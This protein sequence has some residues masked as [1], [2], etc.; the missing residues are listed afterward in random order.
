MKRLKLMTGVLAAGILLCG[1]VDDNIDKELEKLTEDNAKATTA[2]I[3]TKEQET[4]KETETTKEQETSKETETTEYEELT[5]TQQAVSEGILRELIDKNVYCNLYIFCG[6]LPLEDEEIETG[7]DAQTN[8]LYQV[9]EKAFPDYA[10]FEEY[11]RSVYCKE[12]ADMFLY[13]Y[14]FE[15]VQK[16]RDIDGKLYIDLKYDGGKGYYVIWDDY[17]ITIDSSSEDRCEFTV[18]A[19][20]EWPAENPVVEDYVVKGT[21]VYEN[22]RWVL[23]E[24]IY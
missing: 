15:G 2:V 22:N 6:S 8:S 3:T 20:V 18:K 23:T 14:P 17:T 7:T 16:Y 12:T 11:V 13:N 9:S 1:C 10:S 19:A 5:S 4:S 24:M 21:A